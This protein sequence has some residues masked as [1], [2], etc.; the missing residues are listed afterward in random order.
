MRNMASKAEY[1]KKHYERR[2]S[3]LNDYKTQRGCLD[4]GIKE[5]AIVLELDHTSNK[6]N[7]VTHLT[8]ISAMYAEIQDGKCEVRCSNCHR[9]K[10]WFENH[11]LLYVPDYDFQDSNKIKPVRRYTNKI[12]LIRGCLDCQYRRH[13][14]ALEFHH[15]DSKGDKIS[16]IARIELVDIELALHPC[17]VLCSN[18]HRIR[19]AKGD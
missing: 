16:N 18:C 2:L 7:E 1:N 11:N 8:S 9:V 19:H 5:P 17:I 4:C 3:W 12:K 15:L 13:P 14:A 6:T 10:T